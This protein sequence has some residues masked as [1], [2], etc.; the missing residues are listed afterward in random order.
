[1]LALWQSIPPDCPRDL[2]AYIGKSVRNRAHEISRGQNAWKRGGRVQIVGDEFLSMLDDGTDLADQFEAKRAGK[3][4]SD[5][6]QK[7]NKSDKKIFVLRYWMSLEINQITELTGYGES[8]IK[9]SLLRTRKKLA[10]ELK[11]GGFTV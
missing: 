4:I 1:M 5:A 10:E 3:L 7:L 8:R 6:L 9:M 11:K 2:R